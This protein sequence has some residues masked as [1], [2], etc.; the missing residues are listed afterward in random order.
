MRLFTLLATLLLA[1]H[2]AVPKRAQAQTALPAAPIRRGDTGPE[3]AFR[4]GW[5][6][7]AG[8]ATGDSRGLLSDRFAGVLPLGFELGYRL[9][10]RFYFGAY[11]QYGVGFVN[12][13]LGSWAETCSHPGFRCSI[14]SIR[15]GGDVRVHLMPGRRVDPW[16]GTGI[17]YEK[18]IF[19]GYRFDPNT[20]AQSETHWRAS[21]LE[22]VHTD[23]GG[24]QRV[25]QNV[26]IG[27][28]VSVSIGHYSSESNGYPQPGQ[29]SP[30]SDTIAIPSN[31]IHE[32]LMFC[33]RA[34][35]LV[36]L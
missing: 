4:I 27:A 32:W 20:S 33:L 8:D 6:V 13:S 9:H 36:V 16:L 26:S 21:G 10:P 5:G 17:G 31:A 35:Y 15:W 19:D 30:F 11:F 25:S 1:H 2:I 29:R 3:L 24:D 14:S 12:D 7:P 34:S 28:V 22:Y 18:I 23:F